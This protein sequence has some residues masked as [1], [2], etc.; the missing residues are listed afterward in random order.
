MSIWSKIGKWMSGEPKW[1]RRNP[2]YP[3]DVPFEPVIDY[4]GRIITD[5]ELFTR[6]GIALIEK[7]HSAT[8]ICETC[9][10]NKNGWANRAVAIFYQPD[11]SKV[12]EGGSQ[13]F[14]IFMQADPEG[15]LDTHELPGDHLRPMICNAI[16][17]VEQDI[18]GIIADNG[19]II[20]SRYRHDYRWSEDKSV[21]IDGGRDYDRHN[22]GGALVRLRI[23]KDRL[24]LMGLGSAFDAD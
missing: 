12:P 22:L 4:R 21:M 6:E 14:G 3:S 13:W 24:M 16:T 9:V 10:K 19:D 5:P 23:V 7:N 18:T 20:Y 8:Y 2:C 15:W 1:M 17:A 11:P